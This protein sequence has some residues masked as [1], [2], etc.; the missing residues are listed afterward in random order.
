ML[1]W[2]ANVPLDA[3]LGGADRQEKVQTKQLGNFFARLLL[4]CSICLLLFFA[5]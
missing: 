3:D 4:L 2:L 1:F 5:K